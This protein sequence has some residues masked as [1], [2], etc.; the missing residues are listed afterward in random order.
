LANPNRV[1]DPGDARGEVFV[2]DEDFE[3]EGGGVGM[4]DRVPCLET[5]RRPRS[6][7]SSGVPGLAAAI[8]VSVTRE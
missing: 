8:S 2:F 3:Y 4:R 5:S 1:A 7:V 6:A